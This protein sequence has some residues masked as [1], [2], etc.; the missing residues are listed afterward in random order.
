MREAVEPLTSEEIELGDQAIRFG[1]ELLKLAV[2]RTTEPRVALVGCVLAA[3]KL[4]VV[5]SRRGQLDTRAE[6]LRQAGEAYDDE[7]LRVGDGNGAR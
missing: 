4:A 7:W 1:N 3:A 5:F 2:E 6:L